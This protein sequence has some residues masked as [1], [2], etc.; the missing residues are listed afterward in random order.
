VFTWWENRFVVVLHMIKEVSLRRIFLVW[1]GKGIGQWIIFKEICTQVVVD[2]IWNVMAHAQKSYFISRRNGRVHLNRRGR[3]FSRLLA[4]ELCASACKVCTAR[5]SLCSAVMW[6]LLFTHSIP[7]FPL[8]FSTRAS[9]CAITFQLDSTTWIQREYI[10]KSLFRWEKTWSN[11]LKNS[12]LETL[13]CNDHVAG[14]I[15]WARTATTVRRSTLDRT[16]H[17]CLGPVLCCH[18]TPTVLQSRTY[19]QM[20]KCI[21][22]QIFLRRKIVIYRANNTLNYP[23]HS[24]SFMY[25]QR[26]NYHIHSLSFG[27]LTSLLFSE[28]CL[29]IVICCCWK[30]FSYGGHQQAKN[31]PL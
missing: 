20:W 15:L 21:T 30:I 6:R 18:S 4:A 17:S 10:F 8:Y 1:D 25:R 28:G 23:F 5:A 31:W 12:C 13:D 16:L 29:L 3:Q 24:E 22:V 26:E 11:G 2:C 14:Y 9:P 7:L 19:I 27:I